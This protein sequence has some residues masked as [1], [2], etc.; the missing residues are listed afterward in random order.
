MAC[1]EPMGDK[2]FEGNAS[3]HGPARLDPTNGAE[4]HFQQQL[5]ELGHPIQ[6]HPEPCAHRMAGAC[7][8]D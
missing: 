7:W 5:A 6:K 3:H 2:G 8:L 1:P 4:A